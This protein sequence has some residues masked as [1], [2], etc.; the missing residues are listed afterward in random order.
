MDCA[1]R[2][3]QVN[4]QI[5]TT[6]DASSLT[7]NEEA[8]TIAVCDLSPLV[9]GAIFPWAVISWLLTS[10]ACDRLAAG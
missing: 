1:K 10:E 3:P 6:L 8:L 7:R 9:A 4:S 5:R 2:K